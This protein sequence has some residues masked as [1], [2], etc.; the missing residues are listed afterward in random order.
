MT[1]TAAAKAVLEDSQYYYG[2]LLLFVENPAVVV[3]AAARAELSSTVS[4][5]LNDISLLIDSLEL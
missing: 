4:A 3:D 1:D 5:T 2:R